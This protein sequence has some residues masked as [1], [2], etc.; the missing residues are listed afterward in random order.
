[1]QVKLIV[2]GGKV[3][4]TEVQLRLP[5]VLGR[6]R[7]ADLTLGH[8]SISRRHC[9][10]TE[11]D[12]LVVVE[13]LESTNGTFVEEQQVERAALEPGARLRVGPL[14]FVV[15]YDRPRGGT[16]S[17]ELGE[18]VLVETSEPPPEEE[19]ILLASEPAQAILP[20]EATPAE[21]APQVPVAEQP[22]AQAPFASFPGQAEF[23]V[24]GPAEQ[25]EVPPPPEEL[26]QAL[27][28]ENE[29]EDDELR[30]FLEELK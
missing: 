14:T 10:L 29:D 15:V 26:Q 27:A 11:E 21:Q 20:E 4:R 18:E 7:E 1:M 2:V 8:P 30:R 12:G 3:N 22:S 24:P 17:A 9:R 6:S 19:S 5:A 16:T 13:D 28:D 25:P 23:P